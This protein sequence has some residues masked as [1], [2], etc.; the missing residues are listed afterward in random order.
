MNKTTF[1]GKE[2]FDITK[3]KK[4][5]ILNTFSKEKYL[6]LNN[7]FIISTK[8]LRVKRICSVVLDINLISRE[9]KNIANKDHWKKTLMR[10]RS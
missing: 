7:D 2:E 3:I 1:N 6:A 9:G 8:S 4:N 10:C 5:D